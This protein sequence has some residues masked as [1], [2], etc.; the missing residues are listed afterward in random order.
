MQ[1]YL[2]KTDTVISP[3][4]RPA[5][6][7]RVHNLPLGSWLETSLRDLG[8]EVAWIDSPAEVR[9]LPALV[10]SD[11][12]FATFPAL[13]AFLQQARRAGGNHRAALLSS[14]LTEKMVPALQGPLL[15]DSAGQ[16]VRA[17]D[18]YYLDH[19]DPS[20]GW[21]QQ[22]RLLSIPHRVRLR[23]LRTNRQFEAS[24]RFVV[25]LSTVY[26]AP[27]RHWATLLAANLLGMNGFFLRL[28]QRHWPRVA[29][30]PLLA[31]GRSGSL[32]PGV[33]RAKT[34]LAGSRCS[35]AATAHVEAS[36]LGRRVR[37][38]PQAVVRNSVLDDFVEVRA[39]AV[40]DGCVLGPGV[41]V[42]T[43]SHLR[44]CVAEEAACIGARFVQLS[45]FGRECV[46]CP[47]S[48]IADFVMRGSVK[49]NLDG[50]KI[51][52]GSRYLG[53]CLGDHAFL[54][55]TIA[56]PGGMEIP[57]GCQLIPH[58]R[59]MV[60]DLQSPLPPTILRL[61]RGRRRAA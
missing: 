12:L 7:M 14:P 51:P 50:R 13:K 19:I 31:A 35:V 42:E 57:N 36:T 27:V 60:G 33:W 17:Y 9:R 39:G 23:R 32:F 45:V 37:I 4:L 49:V 53:G 55:P 21:D 59:S 3:F 38:E 8:C 58:P 29:L 10:V 40:V 41:I 18:A 52:S 34:Y 47:E 22:A 61:D 24:R 16:Q 26:L 2:L 6:Q 20:R 30:L 11:N 48:G 5:P 15:T 44:G 25:P 43:G 1:A 56:L 46:V 28:A 54:G